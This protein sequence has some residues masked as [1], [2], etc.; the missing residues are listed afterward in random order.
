VPPELMTV[1]NVD[2]LKVL[3]PC[4]AGCPKPLLV[5]ER[6]EVDRISQVGSGKHMRL[7]LRNG[8][9][10]FQAIYF[11]ATPETACIAQG[12]LVDV[13]FTPQVNEYRGERSVQM[14]V[15]DIR[16]SCTA[17]C[18]AERKTTALFVMVY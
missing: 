13:A 11:S 7:R 1:N 16:P 3:E 6:L 4:G 9:H 18:S 15:V 12:D 5:M 14:N 8:R 10:F 17:E 2:S